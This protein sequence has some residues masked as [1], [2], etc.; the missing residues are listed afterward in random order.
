MIP[1]SRTDDEVDQLR[2]RGGNALLTW[3]S[4][5]LCFDGRLAS[6]SW[7]GA[8]KKPKSLTKLS[9]EAGL[10]VFFSPYKLR[11]GRGMASP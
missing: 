5:L 8:E 2:I 3:L 11:E 9:M 6:S 10:V 1:L 7:T 4:W